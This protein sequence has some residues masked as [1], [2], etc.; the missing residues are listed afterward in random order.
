MLA[1][2][3]AKR[4]TFELTMNWQIPI[5]TRAIITYITFLCCRLFF[6]IRFDIFCGCITMLR[7]ACHELRA[8]TIFTH[9]CIRCNYSITLEN[10]CSNVLL[11]YYGFTQP[12]T[13]SG[14]TNK[15]WAYNNV[16]YY[17]LYQYLHL[18]QNIKSRHPYWVL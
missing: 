12:L 16:A 9:N 10:L 1:G 3:I 6:P 15:L 11:K 13:R 8:I 7:F 5:T 14:Q 18:L 17:S 2:L 4:T